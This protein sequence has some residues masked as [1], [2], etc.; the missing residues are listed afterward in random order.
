VIPVWVLGNGGHAKVVLDAITCQARYEVA[1]IL[2]DRP[3]EPTILPGLP[4]QGPV[5]RD[6][7]ERLGVNRAVIAIGSNPV[8]ARLADLLDGLVRFVTVVHPSATVASS[9]SIGEGVVICAGSI[10]QPYATIGDH[11]IINTG[12]T[13]DH[14]S[15]IESF[16]HVAPGSH[17]AGN[18]TVGRGALLGIGSVVVPGVQ[19]GANAVVGAGS[20]VIRDVEAG[21][22]VA[23]VPARPLSS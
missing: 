23:G 12:A 5:T 7:A 2:S 17:L 8:R 22:R 16:S 11:T 21:S 1:G 6:L 14:D 4:H 9:A 3:D 13:V 19:I 20:V 18:V 10:V 15:F